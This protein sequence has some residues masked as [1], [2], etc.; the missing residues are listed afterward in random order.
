MKRF[1]KEAKIVAAG[2]QFGIELDSK[3]LRT[4]EKLSLYTSDAADE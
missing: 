4:P 3:P 2:D 1:Y